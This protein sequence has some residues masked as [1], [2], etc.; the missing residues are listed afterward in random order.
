MILD[1]QS[2]NTEGTLG[3]H[4]KIGLYVEPSVVVHINKLATEIDN[5]NVH[6]IFARE[7]TDTIELLP[8]ADDGCFL[9]F[10]D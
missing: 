4:R 7:I 9:T 3:K 1:L 10:C 2:P 8:F 5:S 6:A